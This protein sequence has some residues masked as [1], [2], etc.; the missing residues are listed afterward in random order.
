M[1]G[2]SPLV[3]RVQVPSSCLDVMMDLSASDDDGDDDEGGDDDVEMSD[4][5]G[6]ATTGEQGGNQDLSKYNLDSYDKEE[7]KGAGLWLSSRLRR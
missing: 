1:G 3:Y 4:A 6:P 5:Q 7:S 2:V